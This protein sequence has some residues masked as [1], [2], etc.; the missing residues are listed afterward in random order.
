[1]RQSLLRVRSAGSL[2]M[3]RS[4]Q[5]DLVSPHLL[6]LFWKIVDGEWVR[7][8]LLGSVSVLML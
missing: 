2:S 3:K 6:L 7:S 1:M 4:S 8:T 5:K